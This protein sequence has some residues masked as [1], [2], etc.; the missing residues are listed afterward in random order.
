MIRALNEVGIEVQCVAGTSMGALIGAVYASGML[1]PLE[2]VYLDFDWKRI[3]MLFDVT[4]PKSGLIDGK[5][6]GNFVRQY[7]SNEHIQDLPIPFRAVTT[8]IGIGEEVVIGSG[9]VI[10]A[11]RAS[12]SVPGIF[13]PVKWDDRILVDGGLVNPVPV[14][15]VR[16]M[17]AGQVIAVDLNHQIVSGKSF[18]K[19]S[20]GDGDEPRHW[21]RIKSHLSEL[22]GERY[23]QWMERISS[24][25]QGYD[26]KALRQLRAW[27]SDEALPNIFEVLLSSINIMETQITRARLQID[28]PD[29]LIQPPLGDIRFLEYNRADEIISIGY[30]AAVETLQGHGY[31]VDGV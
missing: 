1:D 8:D 22:G 10:D 2:Q 20:P 29:I 4:L 21:D 6:V 24:G 17:G 27:Q 28:A 15:V 18:D 13:T 5:K 16:A 30:E 26:S 14:S 9:D 7:I 25:L 31:T 12:I 19:K 23:R 3:T 11:V